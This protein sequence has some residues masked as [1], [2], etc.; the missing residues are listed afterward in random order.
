MRFGFDIVVLDLELNNPNQDNETIIEIGAVKFLRD[1][2]IHPSIFTR[3]I[4]IEEPLSPYIIE[5]TGITDQ[6]IRNSGVSLA[7]AMNDMEAWAKTESKNIVLGSWGSD[8]HYL[9][10]YCKDRGINWPFRGKAIDVKSI[11]IWLNA[12]FNLPRK[13][14][15]LGSTMGAW[16]LEFDTQYG[17]RHRALPDAYNTALLMQRFLSAHKDEGDKILKSLSKLGIK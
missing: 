15:G 3:V 5:L 17:Q 2:G 4:S 7:E 14:D 11:A 1:G 9:R 6:E 8:V 10:Q 12:M 16:E 13:S